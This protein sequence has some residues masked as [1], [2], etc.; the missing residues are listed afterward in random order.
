[1]S[2]H[3]YVPAFLEQH[4]PGGSSAFGEIPREQRLVNRPSLEEVFASMPEDR[5]VLIA[6]RECAY[7]LREITTFLHV[8]SSTVSRRLRQQEEA[9]EQPW[10]LHCKT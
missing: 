4:V 9:D 10:M 2:P 1:M 6:Y 7:K 8:H 3:F 5:A